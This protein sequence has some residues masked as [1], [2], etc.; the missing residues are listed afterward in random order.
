MPSR[1]RYSQ[2][3]PI[4]ALLATLALMG[5]EDGPANVPDPDA[6]IEVSLRDDVMPLIL[7]SCGGCH[8]DTDAPFPPAVVNGVVYQSADDILALVGSFI[9]AGDS[10]NSGFLAILTQELAVG[11][12]PTLMPPP[13]LAAPMSADDV[14]I[15]ATWIDQGARDN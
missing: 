8:T 14:Q 10:A 6:G 11:E 1:H 9:I 13:D 5:C 12:G 7:Q 2:G 3:V 15:V 4:I